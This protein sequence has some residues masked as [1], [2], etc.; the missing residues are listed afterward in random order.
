MTAVD[1]VR[2]CPTAVSRSPKSQHVGICGLLHIIMLLT[3]LPAGIYPIDIQCGLCLYI[4]G[5]QMFVLHAVYIGLVRR[6]CSRIQGLCASHGKYTPA[7]YW[8]GDGTN[9]RHFTTKLGAALLSG[10]HKLTFDCNP[11]KNVDYW[12]YCTAVPG[13]LHQYIFEKLKLKLKVK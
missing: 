9:D 11:C 3:Y 13:P 12:A 1:V 7:H 8:S 4:R 10:K 6:L 2:T 5:N